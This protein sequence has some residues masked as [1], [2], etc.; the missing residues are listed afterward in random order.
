VLDRIKS[1]KHNF[2]EYNFVKELSLDL[3][4]YYPL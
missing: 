2:P 4:S 3:S 1:N